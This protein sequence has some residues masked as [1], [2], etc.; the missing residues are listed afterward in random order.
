MS[1][2]SSSSSD[3]CLRKQYA[4]KVAVIPERYGRVLSPCASIRLQAFTQQFA[5]DVR[6][7]IAEEVET[8]SPDVVLWNRGALATVSAV[9][10]L[11][12]VARESGARLIYDLDDNLLAM[13]EHP[14]R[15]SYLDMVGAVRRSIEL[16]DEVWC[17]TQSLVDAVKAAGGAAVLMPNTLDACMWKRT[18][19]PVEKRPAGAPLKMIYMGTRTHDEDYRLL[20]MALVEIE[21]IRPGT[22]SLTLVGVNAQNMVLHPWITVLSPPAHIGASYPAFVRWFV[23]QGP[24]DLGLAP[25]IDTRF[26][27]GKSSIKVLDYAAI[28]LATLASSVAGYL[29]DFQDDRVLV[30]N[31]VQDWVKA[32]L[33]A[34]D[35]TI[36]LDAVR[37]RAM[38]LV[39]VE[40]FEAA[41]AE[42]W[43]RCHMLPGKPPAHH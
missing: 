19:S 35:G 27:R 13:D 14:E 39:T 36:D 26:N 11:V 25:L 18:V 24:F 1:S 23:Q 34:L 31:S 3:A 20:E 10:A 33:G 4:I 6:Y 29:E 43:A 22:F 5:A 17:S 37:T 32:L 21:R 16:A 2:F 30:Q 9:D 38:D 41:V 8:F 12:A 7:L 28:G 42:R 15:E 40:R